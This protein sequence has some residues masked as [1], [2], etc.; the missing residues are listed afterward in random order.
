[1]TRLRQDEIYLYLRRGGTISREVGFPVLEKAGTF[2][3]KLLT[4]TK[5]SGSVL[6][7][8]FSARL[9]EEDENRLPGVKI[10][11][12]GCRGRT[13]MRQGQNRAVFPAG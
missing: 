13:R 11:F 5:L 4:K 3:T 12:V 7:K 9:D 8:T 2:H 1:M 6:S 10:C